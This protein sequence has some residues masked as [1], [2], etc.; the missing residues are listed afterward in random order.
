MKSCF[1]S[2][3][4]TFVCLIVLPLALP[5]VVTAADDSDAKLQNAAKKMV[6]RMMARFP[7][8]FDKLLSSDGN[9]SARLFRNDAADQQEFRDYIGIDKESAENIRKKQMEVLE[10]DN[11]ME[12][13]LKIA[14]ASTDAEIDRL[15]DEMI[16]QMNN[17][18]EEAAAVLTKELNPQ[19]LKK[20]AELRMVHSSTN[21][22][23]F[24]F[25]QYESLDLTDEQQKQISVIRAEYLSAAEPLFNNMLAFQQRKN[26]RH[27]EMTE[28]EDPE[29]MKKSMEDIQKEMEEVQQLIIKL[30]AATRARI[31]TLFTKEQTAKLEKVLTN[32][33]KYLLK[34]L[35]L[36]NKD[37]WKPSDSSWK[38]G[39]GPTAEYLE[40]QR[41]NPK[42]NKQ[43]PRSE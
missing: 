30:N 25:D 38:P 7:K 40:R 22:R 3:V 41:Q 20:L 2:S 35:G 37:A 4:L 12:T 18:Q 11:S 16:D 10:K 28:S 43:F 36:E 5:A 13:M 26:E 6:P 33:P 29:A 19:K 32:A 14:Q 27:F 9:G 34:R 42:T 17:V 8:L 31:L 21:D 1:I 24:D 15:L 23:P 39:D